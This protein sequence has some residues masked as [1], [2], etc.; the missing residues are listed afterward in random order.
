MASF[1]ALICLSFDITCSVRVMV[2]Q[3]SASAMILITFAISSQIHSAT[4]SSTE[5]FVISAKIPPIVL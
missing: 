5:F 3:L 4:E 1:T 2:S